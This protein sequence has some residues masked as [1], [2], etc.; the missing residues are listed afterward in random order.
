MDYFPSNTSISITGIVE[1]PAFVI[2]SYQPE[3]YLIAVSLERKLASCRWGGCRIGIACSE[4][5]PDR[6][7][8][9]GKI[10][11]HTHRCCY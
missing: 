9:V 6:R 4:E 11:C 2:E 1:S 10:T 5:T 3:G 7:L 8:F